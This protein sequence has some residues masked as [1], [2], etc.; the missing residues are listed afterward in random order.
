MEKYSSCYSGGARQRSVEKVLRLLASLPNPTDDPIIRSA[1]NILPTRFEK[2]QFA[3]FAF[4]YGK[5]VR[6]LDILKN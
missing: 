4:L 3:A 5:N 2:L 6:F 1:K